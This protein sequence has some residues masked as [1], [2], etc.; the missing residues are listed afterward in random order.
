[1]D[2]WSVKPWKTFADKAVALKRAIGADSFPIISRDKHPQHWRDWYAYYGYRRMLASQEMMREKDEKTVPT[3]SPFDFDA[4]FN[5]RYPSPEV[6][7]NR[8]RGAVKLTP[9]QR[10]RHAAIYPWLSGNA[11]HVPMPNETREDAA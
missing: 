2:D 6:P 9:E 7:N 5:P 8:S 3:V 10:A 1:M 4:E 11:E